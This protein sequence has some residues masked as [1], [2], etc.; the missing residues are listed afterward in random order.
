MDNHV[1]L[2][3]KVDSLPDRTVALLGLLKLSQ[4]NKPPTTAC[5][6]DAA[7]DEFIQGKLQGQAREQMLTHL[8]QCP[9]CYQYWID[10]LQNQPSAK[11]IK[12]VAKP[13]AWWHGLSDILHLHPWQAATYFA[14]IAVFLAVFIQLQ[15]LYD[16]HPLSNIEKSYISLVSQPL[17]MPEERL[18]G[19]GEPLG[20]LEATPYSTKGEFAQCLHASYEAIQAAKPRL[21]TVSRDNN[22]VFCELAQ[23]IAILHTM[24][25]NSERFQL[26]EP[27]QQQLVISQD[28]Q[29]RLPQTESLLK[30]LQGIQG[31]IAWV[32]QDPIKRSINRRITNNLPKTLDNLIQSPF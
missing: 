23:W 2:R 16:T 26:A 30:P 3:Q 27:W 6:T 5:P 10:E 29:Q 11:P 19:L 21:D 1:T 13:M 31:H 12:D 20:F 22:Q 7:L 9:D 24:S 15:T 14:T 32:I 8:N 25:Q 28:F 18:N 17:I 4:P